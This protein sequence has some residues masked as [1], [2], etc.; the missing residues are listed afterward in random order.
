M[1]ALKVFQ[2]LLV[3]LALAS[4][5]LKTSSTT[6]LFSTRTTDASALAYGHVINPAPGERFYGTKRVKRTN[7]E[8]GVQR[9]ARVGEPI[10]RTQIYD[11]HTFQTNT[12]KASDNFTLSG[13]ATNIRINKDQIYPIVGTITLDD[14]VFDVVKV[15]AKDG[16]IG[17]NRIF[18]EVRVGDYDGALIDA[19]GNIYHKLV[20]VRDGRASVLNHR[21]FVRPTTATFKPTVTNRVIRGRDSFDYELR[22]DGLHD[23]TIYTTYLDFKP[24]TKEKAGQFR[25]LTYPEGASVIRVHDIDVK[26]IDVTEDRIEYIVFNGP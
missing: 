25:S 6:G 12:V 2:A 5:T 7:F 8:R 15:G 16:N 11:V 13:G 9:V 14:R 4:C 24:L 21:F 23:G 3:G 17:R 18:D 20:A 10:L 19:R 22:F 1:K 26:I